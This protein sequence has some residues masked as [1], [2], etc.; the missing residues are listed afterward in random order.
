[1]KAVGGNTAATVARI[2]ICTVTGA[3]TPGTS[4]TAGNT[5]L[6]R[7]Y[8]LLATTAT[9]TNALADA[10]IPIRKY[11]PAGYRLLIGFGTST[12]AAGIGYAV[13]TF[14]GKL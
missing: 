8:S 11:I 14:G 6:I 2:F 5:A 1:M 3:F 10:A 13:T 4:N 12:G 7:E 9:N